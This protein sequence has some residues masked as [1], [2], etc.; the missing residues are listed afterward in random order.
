MVASISFDLDH[1]NFITGVLQ[2]SLMYT[3]QWQRR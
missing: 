2:T 1:K 3:Q